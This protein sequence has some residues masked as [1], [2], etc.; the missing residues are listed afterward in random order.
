MVPR[1]VVDGRYF[2]VVFPASW[3]S[4]DLIAMLWLTCLVSHPL[5]G[6]IKVRAP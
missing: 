3:V 6:S 2:F 1:D 5:R 4:Q